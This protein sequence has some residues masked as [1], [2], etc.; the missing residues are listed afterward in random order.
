MK[1]I[2]GKDRNQTKFFSLDQA[3]S[4]DNEVRLIDSI[5]SLSFIHSF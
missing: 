3:V 1:F 4:E 2:E 5:V